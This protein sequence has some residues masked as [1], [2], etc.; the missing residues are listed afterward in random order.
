[1]K[2]KEL[3]PSLILLFSLTGCNYKETIEIANFESGAMQRFLILVDFEK[4]CKMR[5]CSLS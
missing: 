3:V 5:L 4:C 2:I 1:M